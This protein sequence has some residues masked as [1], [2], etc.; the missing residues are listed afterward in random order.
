MTLEQAKIRMDLLI[1]TIAIVHGPPRLRHTRLDGAK[2]ISERGS[3]LCFD[4]VWFI[5]NSNHGIALEYYRDD[6]F[7]IKSWGKFGRAFSVN[8]WTKDIQFPMLMDAAHHVGLLTE[9]E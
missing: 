3:Y 4:A 1:Q 6:L 5:K 9:Q 2:G 7:Q 8:F